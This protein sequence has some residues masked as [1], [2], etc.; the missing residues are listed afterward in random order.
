[1]PSIIL[2]DS[3]ITGKDAGQQLPLLGTLPQLGLVAHIC[4]LSTQ[5]TVAENP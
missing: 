1:M 3:Q 5:K 4:D 2:Q